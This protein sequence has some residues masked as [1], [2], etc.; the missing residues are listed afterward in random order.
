MSYTSDVRGELARLPYADACCARSEL[1][2]ALL[3]SGGIAW[4]GRNRYAV[5]LTAADAPTV[6]RFFGMLK[7]FWNVVG[8]IRTIASDTLNGQIRYQLAV[9]ES[10]AL[11]LLEALNLLDAA[12]PFGIRQLPAGDT[13]SF[14]CCRKAFARAAFL[15]CGAM[16]PPEKKSHF[17]IAAPNEALADFIAEQFIYFGI[18]VKTTCRKSK[19]V[20]Y[21][22]RAES[23]SDALTLLG[24]SAAVLTF[25]NTRVKKEVSNQVNRRLNCD[26][27]NINRVMKAA[28]AQLRDIRYIDDELGLEKLPKPLRDMAEIRAANPGAALGELGELLDPPIG[29][30]GVNARLRKLADIADK[31]RSGEEINLEIHKR[32]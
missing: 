9:P 19:Y 6:R 20:V 16:N 28:E 24:A 29:K 1:T 12:Q 22:K 27:S 25:E 14:A 3:A 5:T 26:N 23:I 21:L 18:N 10:E 7:Q 13:V 2:A 31:L 8:Q 17:E 11:G 32:G 4:R 30:S 15:M